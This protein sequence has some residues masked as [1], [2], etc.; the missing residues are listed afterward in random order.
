LSRRQQSK[1]SGAARSRADLE[2]AVRARKSIR[3]KV[4]R[5][6][7]DARADWNTGYDLCLA[8]LVRAI[9]SVKESELQIVI[10]VGWNATVS[11]PALIS[12][13]ARLA[14]DGAG[15]QHYRENY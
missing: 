8:D 7:E 3:A 13:A 4:E 10:T 6:R 5:H 1:R 15:A 14:K 2:K 11:Q 12:E 9:R